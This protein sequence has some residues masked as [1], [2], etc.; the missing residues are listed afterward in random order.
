MTGK[1]FFS[2][3]NIVSTVM[4]RKKKV[5]IPLETLCDYLKHTPFDQYLT[6]VTLS[7]FASCFDEVVKSR[8]GKEIALDPH[9]VYVVCQGEVDLST[10]YPEVEGKVEAKGFLC[11]KRR[12]DIINV[13]QTERDVKR[14]MTV[15]IGKVIDV[16]EDIITTGSGEADIVLV[17]S[18]MKSLNDFTA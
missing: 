16:A 3:R 10:S 5:V 14:R 2:V 11:R 4:K 7:E 9:K 6:P 17:S 1:L 13:T 8:P 18:T 12:G 15:K